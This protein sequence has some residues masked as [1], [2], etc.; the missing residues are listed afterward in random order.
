MQQSEVHE[1]LDFPSTDHA[2]FADVEDV[3]SA[4]DES[5]VVMKTGM[6]GVNEGVL[7]DAEAGCQVDQFRVR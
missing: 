4:S 3:E 2:I 5:L 6:P 7:F 1:T